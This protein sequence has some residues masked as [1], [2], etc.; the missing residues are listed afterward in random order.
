MKKILLAASLAALLLS[1]GKVSENENEFK[2][3]RFVQHAG[4]LIPSY[5][6]SSPSS[7]AL[8]K[9]GA[10]TAI[11]SRIEFTESGVYVVA[12]KDADGTAYRTGAYT[13][14]GDTYNLGGFGTV[15]FPHA[16]PGKV[17]VDVN[18]GTASTERIQAEFKKSAVSGN[19]LHS[20]WTVD[21]TRVTVRGWTTASADF[22]GCNIAEIINFLKQNGHNVPDDV[23]P[24]LAIHSVSF[25]GT[26][27]MIFAYSDNSCDMASYTLTNGSSLTFKWEDEQMG[28]T[29]LTDTGSVEYMDGK[30]ILTIRVQIQD[31]TVTGSVTFVLSQ[32][33]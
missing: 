14:S 15:T 16:T 32:M 31:S 10:G 29:F 24:N 20:G 22:K 2:E 23:S 5:P 17:E 33:D 18:R 19:P 13:V 27:A 7:R 4:Q 30:C 3:P 6:D 9:A 12:E 11:L 21:K 28:Y 26:G 8:T 1:C 25:T